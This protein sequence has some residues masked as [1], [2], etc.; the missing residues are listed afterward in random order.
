MQCCARCGKQRRALG[1][2]RCEKVCIRGARVCMTHGGGSIVKARRDLR[3]GGDIYKS[4]LGAAA[5]KLF[6]KHIENPKILDTEEDIALIGTRAE[7]MVERAK[8][9]DSQQFRR[10]AVELLEGLKDAMRS[11][12]TTAAQP[13][14]ASV[15]SHGWPWNPVSRAET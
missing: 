1:F 9:G 3:V 13:L 12:D 10:K 5:A 6:Q 2:T 11:G 14:P 8:D 4:S 15:S 7:Q